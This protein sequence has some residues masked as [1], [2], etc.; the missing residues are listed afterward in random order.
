[1]LLLLVALP[2]FIW[3]VM[4]Q[5]IELRKKAATSEP[6][7][8]C[9]NR[10]IQQNDVWQWPDGCK[11]NPRTDIACIQVLVPLSTEENTRYS[12][13]AQMGR[14]FIPGCRMPEEPSPTP[15][16]LCTSCVT[17]HL[18]PNGLTCQAIQ[19]G[20]GGCQ[21]D[22][23][24]HTMCYDPAIAWKCAPPNNPSACASSPVNSCLN[25]INGTKCVESE[26]CPSYSGTSSVNPP[27]CVLAIGHCL[28]GQCVRGTVS[29]TPPPVVFPKCTGSGG[30][31]SC[32][33]GYSCTLECDPT[34]PENPNAGCIPRSA[35]RS[36]SSTISFPNCNVRASRPP[37]GCPSGYACINTCNPPPG[38]VGCAQYDVCRQNPTPSPTP[39]PTVTP[40]THVSPSLTVDKQKLEGIAGTVFYSNIT[41]L[42]RDST[43]CPS[44]TFRLTAQDFPQ[45]WSWRIDGFHQDFITLSPQT[46]VI[47]PITV[48]SSTNAE[49][50]EYVLSF[51]SSSNTSDFHRMTVQSTYKILPKPTSA[52]TP[53]PTPLPN[54]TLELKVK[55]AGV[56]AGLADGAKISVKFN[57]KDGT[58]LQLSQPLTLHYDSSGVYKTSA[59]LTN[60]FPAGTEFTIKVKGEKHVAV[61]FC[62]QV[63]QTGPCGDTD[64]ISVPNPVPLSYGFDLTGIPLPPGDLSPQD[65]TVNQNDLTRL[66]ALKSIFSTDQTAA[67]K[68]IADLNYDGTINSFDLFLILQTLMTRNDE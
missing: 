21:D 67:D 17:N 68:L 53:T 45:T 62:K 27:Q 34:A 40:C 52:P 65:G 57:K 35:C 8:I 51:T 7:Q 22:G 41:L 30:Q 42:N 1:M 47:L 29:P 49:P 3:A 60:P 5:R 58:I 16:N 33:T 18:C 50:Y 24:G 61:K 10:V 32:P 25:I 23:A 37:I 66:I 20:P 55:L 59:I 13:W 43:A 36:N 56:S 14:P 6:T 46:Q 48:W 64:Y 26:A 28:N 9:W 4:T 2:V 44:S 38:Q 63:G 54:Q 39:S 12:E 31:G 19:Q 15:T 11:G